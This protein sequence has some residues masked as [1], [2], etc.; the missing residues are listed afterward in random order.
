MHVEYNTII[1]RYSTSI[2]ISTKVTIYQPNSFL[3]G[4]TEVP[5]DGYS[6]ICNNPVNSWLHLTDL[7]HTIPV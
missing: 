1:I 6:S 4:H 7:L 2:L 3:V 5:Q